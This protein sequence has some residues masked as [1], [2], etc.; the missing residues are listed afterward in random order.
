[1]NAQEQTWLNTLI[2]LAAPVEKYAQALRCP[3]QV[4]VREMLKLETEAQ[5]AAQ[6]LI[7][8]IVSAKTEKMWFA[9]YGEKK[10]IEASAALWE[11]YEL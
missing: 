9:V 8:S 6:E 10:V 11:G 3:D 7:A 5:N 2:G 1:M 4:T